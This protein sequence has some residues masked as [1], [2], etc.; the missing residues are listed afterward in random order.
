M[1]EGNI[2]LVVGSVEIYLPLTSMVDQEEERVRLEKEL[3][4]TE[5]Q[6]ERL[7]KLLNSPFVKKAPEPVVQKERDKLAGYKE[8]AERLRSQLMD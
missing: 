5:S 2:A 4:E 7:E 1:S 8:T 6:I 3:L